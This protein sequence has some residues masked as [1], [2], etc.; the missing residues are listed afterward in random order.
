MLT[1]P[2][3]PFY[4]AYTLRLRFTLCIIIIVFIKNKMF[5]WVNV[6]IGRDYCRLCFLAT[7]RWLVLCINL[8]GPAGTHIFG[9]TLFWV[10]LWQSVW[11]RLTFK[12]VNL[13]ESHNWASLVLP[14]MQETWVWSLD[15]EDPLE[16]KMAIHSSILAWDNP[17]D[18]GAWWAI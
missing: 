9:Q 13:E 4:S 11:K 1:L 16:N 7:V 5:S 14:A 3:L 6:H 2:P 17:M 18:R 15:G 12:L 10:F 8:A